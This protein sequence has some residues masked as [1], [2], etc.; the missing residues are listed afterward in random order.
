LFAT[1]VGRFINVAA[2]ELMRALLAGA[3]K[4]ARQPQMMG[5]GATRQ[6]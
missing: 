3:H 1:L 4:N 6:I 2:K 5:A